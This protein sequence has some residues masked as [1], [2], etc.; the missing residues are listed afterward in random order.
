MFSINALVYMTWL[1]RNYG[2]VVLYRDY[3]LVYEVGCIYGACF[4]VWIFYMLWRRYFNSFTLL[5]FYTLRNQVNAQYVRIYFFLLLRRTRQYRFAQST[6]VCWGLA[7]DTATSKVQISF[8][9][10]KNYSFC[11]VQ[12]FKRDLLSKTKRSIST[13]KDLLEI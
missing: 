8:F 4:S 9:R 3:R 11:C 6:D 1:A 2:N 7:V 10:N 12:F 13:T 5:I